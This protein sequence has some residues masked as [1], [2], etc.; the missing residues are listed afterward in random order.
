[1]SQSYIKRVTMFQVAKEEDIDAVVAQYDILRST[2][3]KNGAPYIVANEAAR[4]INS[5]EERSQGFT[6]I[7]ITTFKSKEDVEYYD[8]GCAAHKKLREFVATRRNG[9]RMI[10]SCLDKN[11]AVL[12]MPEFPRIGAPGTYTEPALPN[13]GV[14]LQSQFMPDGLLSDYERYGT[15]HDNMLH[16]RRK[17]PVRVRVPIF[18]DTETPWPWRESRQFPHKNHAQESDVNKHEQVDNYIYGDSMAFG[19]T[20][21]GLQVTMQMKDLAQCRYIHDQLCVLA[22]VIMA[23]SAAT[24]FF[25]GLLTDWD[26]R[27]NQAASAIE[28][29]TLQE[30]QPGVKRSHTRPRWSS[31]PMFIS[32]DPRM[33]AEYNSNNVEFDTSIKERLEE[34]GMDNLLASHYANILSRDPIAMTKNEVNSYQDVELF[35]IIHSAIWPHVDFKLPSK[36]G[37]AGWRVEFRPS[38]IQLSDFDNAAF[39]IFINMERAHTRNAVGNEKFFFRQQVQAKDNTSHNDNEDECT[40]LT[41]NEIINGRIEGS[42]AESFTGLLPLIQAYMQ[43]T[44]V[45]PEEEKQ[46]TKYLDVVRRRANGE[47]LT[48]ATWMRQFVRD[49]NDYHHD[50]IVS[51]TVCYDLLKVVK[52]LGDGKAHSVEVLRNK[53]DPTGP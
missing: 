48:P 16:R 3:E 14:V 7:A 30:L 34:A 35:E 15:I 53:E 50:S 45:S 42:R 31:T 12:S 17:R 39:A 37:K 29:R 32:S 20:A 8:K 11:E 4:V 38:E 43:E 22:P 47:L 27:W 28:D 1:M 6:V 21:C 13:N 52:D 49:H 19:P 9:R 36:D 25:R 40:E 18:K 26:L 51:E 24:P 2:A 10:Q 41:V 46:I 33:R 5:S 23:L 44:G